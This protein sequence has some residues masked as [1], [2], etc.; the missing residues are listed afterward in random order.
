MSQTLKTTTPQ[1]PLPLMGIRLNQIIT[2]IIIPKNYQLLNRRAKK[3][4]KSTKDNTCSKAS[5]EG[6]NNIGHRSC[7]KERYKIV[8]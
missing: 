2:S 6:E 7:R 4:Q 5:Y 8:G 3:R 1:L